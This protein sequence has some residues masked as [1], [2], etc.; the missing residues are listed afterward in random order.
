V[1]IAVSLLLFFCLNAK[2]KDRL[3]DGLSEIDQVFRS[4]G[5]AV[6][7]ARRYSAL[8]RRRLISQ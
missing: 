8:R 4:A 6:A 5:F 1:V 2:K 7:T 3:C